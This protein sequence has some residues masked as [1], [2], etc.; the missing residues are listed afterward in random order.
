MQ[1]A[2]VILFFQATFTR[3]LRAAVGLFALAI[4]VAAINHELDGH[5]LGVGV[6]LITAAQVVTHCVGG[7]IN[8]C[9]LTYFYT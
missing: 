4:V 3:L 9:G 5:G 1:L 2:T 8:V 7:R 6:G